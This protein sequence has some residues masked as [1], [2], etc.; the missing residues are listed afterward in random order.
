MRDI[1]IKHNKLAKT[2]FIPND[3][4][5]WLA[6]LNLLARQRLEALGIDAIYGGEF[7]TYTRED[8]F[9]SY[10]RNGQTGRMANL[11]YRL[12]N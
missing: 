6:D 5:H 1:F 2:A 10:R 7:C 8:L 4:E 12:E 9:F 11:I 3:N